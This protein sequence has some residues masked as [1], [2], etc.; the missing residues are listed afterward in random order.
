M[1]VAVVLRATEAGSNFP[2]ATR[3]RTSKVS[4]PPETARRERR[5]N[6]P[7]EM[8]RRRADGRLVEPAHVTFLISWVEFPEACF[9]LVD[10]ASVVAAAVPAAESQSR[11]QGRHRRWEGHVPSRRLPQMPRSLLRFVFTA[12]L[13][14]F[15]IPLICLI[16]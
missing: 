11:V 9:G 7:K 4:G 5:G 12:F 14:L 13:F 10:V 1:V 2:C 6:E 16:P 3:T 8:K 15:K